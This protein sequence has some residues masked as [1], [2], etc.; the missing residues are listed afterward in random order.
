M[1]NSIKD[2]RKVLLLLS[3]TDF[4]SLLDEASSRI[5]ELEEDL[6]KSKD[7]AKYL[8]AQKNHL[9]EVLSRRNSEA[10]CLRQKLN[11]SSR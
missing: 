4:V 2:L 11:S 8:E 9:L 5:K 6:Q 1:D 3:D 7:E 10:F